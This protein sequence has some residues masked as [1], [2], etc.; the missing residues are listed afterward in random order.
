LNLSCDHFKQS[1]RATDKMLQN[2]FYLI[3]QNRHC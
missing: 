3:K 2:S 1:C